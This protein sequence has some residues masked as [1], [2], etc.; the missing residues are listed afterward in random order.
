VTKNGDK[1]SLP[2][3]IGGTSDE[4]IVVDILSQDEGLWRLLLK[5]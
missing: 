4:Y 5:R 1:V 2:T 3:V